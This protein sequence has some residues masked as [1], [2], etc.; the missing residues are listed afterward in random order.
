MDYSIIIPVK[1][2]NDYIIQNIS[3]ILEARNNS[4]E[5]FILPNNHEKNIFPEATVKIIPTGKVAPGIKRDIGAKEAKGSYLVFLDDD[6]FPFLNFFEILDE[7]ISDNPEVPAFG[8]PGI[9]PSSNTNLQKASGAFFGSYFGGGFPERYRPIGQ[10]RFC[11]DWPSVNLIVKSSV[12]KSINGF[13]SHFWP[14]EDTVLCNKIILM[15]GKRILYSPELLVFHHRRGGW[16]KHMNQIGNYGYFRGYLVKTDRGNSLTIK[17]FVPSIFFLF[18]LF[19]LY[20]TFFPFEYVFQEFITLS[21]S[22]IWLIYLVLNIA[23]FIDGFRQFGIIPG[24]L[25]FFYTTP[26]HLWY[27]AKFIQGLLVLKLNP[28]LR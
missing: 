25:T 24:L 10:S 22:M 3:H 21:L 11:N 19:S 23:V 18:S 1:S 4:I 2:I 20:S 15:T 27:G 12:F 28:R 5:I 8:G 16:Y 6:S 14:G 26:S 7:L 17:A 13:N 9:T